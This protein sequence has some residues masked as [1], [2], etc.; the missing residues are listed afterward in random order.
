MTTE[1]HTEEAT[2]HEMRIMGG[3][4]DTKIV[5]S[6]DNADEVASAQRTFYELRDKGF[7]AFSVKRSGDKDERITEFDPDA[8]SL[9]M[10]PRLAGG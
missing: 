1:V 3:N 5:W 10:V 8:Q 4:G 7:T 6:R 2:T 9:I